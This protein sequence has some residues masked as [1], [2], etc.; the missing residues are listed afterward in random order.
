MK[1]GWWKIN[2]EI[3]LGLAV[4]SVVNQDRVP[5]SFTEIAEVC[6][7]HRSRIEQ[8]EKQA[9]RKIRARLRTEDWR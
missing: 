1:T 6:G 8:L 7:C 5:L 2:P 3:D 9:L 4:L